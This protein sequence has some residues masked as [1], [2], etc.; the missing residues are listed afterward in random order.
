MTEI[1]RRLRLARRSPFCHPPVLDG[2][3]KQILSTRFS[4]GGLGG[5]GCGS[6]GS[7]AD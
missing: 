3:V 5:L 6:G 2:R 4:D 7:L 1:R